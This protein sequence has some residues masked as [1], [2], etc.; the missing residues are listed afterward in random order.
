MS[1]AWTMVASFDNMLHACIYGDVNTVAFL[2]VYFRRRWPL[3]IESSLTCYHIYCITKHSFMDPW[4]S[5]L[6]HCCILPLPV[7]TRL[8][9]CKSVDGR[10]RTLGFRRRICIF[11][12]KSYRRSWFGLQ[13]RTS[14]YWIKR[15]DCLKQKRF[16]TE[17]TFSLAWK[18]N[19]MIL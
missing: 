10:T 8:I 11:R 12:S 19:Y 13:W 7:L 3:S 5:H 17:T 6:W 1:Y 4:V 15:T 14:S 18:V 2:C 16:F 9:A